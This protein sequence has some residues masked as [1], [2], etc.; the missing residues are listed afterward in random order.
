MIL[1]LAIDVG[2]GATGLVAQ[3]AVLVEVQPDPGEPCLRGR[4]HALV[5]PAEPRAAEVRP[6]Q[7][8]PAEVVCLASHRHPSATRSAIWRMNVCCSTVPINSMF[9]AG[10]APAK[11]RMHDVLAHA[12]LKK[13][14]TFQ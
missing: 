7:V 3:P 10:L 8:G 1:E 14:N 2:G 9:G 12:P 6:D 11:A 13:L 4:R 5:E